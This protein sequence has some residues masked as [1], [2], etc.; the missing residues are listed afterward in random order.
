MLSP[1]QMSG[2]SRGQHAEAAPVGLGDD[3]AA[4]G[5]PGHADR[6]VHPGGE[7]LARVGRAGDQQDPAPAPVG[8][9]A[10]VV[11][12]GQPL[13]GR[14]HAD[15]GH[16]TGGRHRP[17]LAAALL[18]PQGDH[19]GRA[20]RGRRT[21]EQGHVH[22]AVGGAD[23]P[24][25]HALDGS[26]AE[27]G[28][29]CQHGDR[30][31]PA[32]AVH[33]QHGVGGRVAHVPAVAAVP[34][35]VIRVAGQ[36]PPVRVGR[37]LV[38]LQVHHQAV[39]AAQRAEAGAFAGGV[40]DDRAHGPVGGHGRPARPGQ[41]GV[42]LPAAAG[43]RQLVQQHGAAAGGQVDGDHLAV[44]GAR[45]LVGDEQAAVGG[46]VH[47]AGGLEPGQRVRPGAAGGGRDQ[48]AGG[49]EHS[50]DAPAHRQGTVLG[51]EVAVG[52]TGPGGIMLTG[53]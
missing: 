5:E 27:G 37:P 49:P 19:D 52:P 24:G 44:A 47:R 28:H 17:G 20:A 43:R 3:V 13:R 30:P 7:D 51:H 14:G 31:D 46:Q 21:A 29:A 36:L 1:D 53:C 42:L 35:H 15:W 38:G 11:E 40:A 25:G 50:R 9:P 48:Q 39:G 22:A 6:S 12:H 45:A 23:E 8:R 26:A 34:G 18:W 16:A 10:A 2:P 33:P 32:G 41:V 4:V